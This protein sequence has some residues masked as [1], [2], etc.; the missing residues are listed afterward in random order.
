MKR[1]LFAGLLG[2]AAAPALAQ[3]G[4]TEIEHEGRGLMDRWVIAFNRGDADAMAADVY[5]APDTEALAKRFADLRAESFGKLDVYGAD[6][7]GRDST[8]GRAI[9][10]FARIYT[11]GGQMN[12]DE[13]KVFDFEKTGAGW[14]ITSE[15]DA[16]YATV[17]GC[18]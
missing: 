9:L 6:F 12:G 2:L 10:K 17:L 4:A 18:D 14:R 15:T 11:F 13:A 3:Q 5:A 8:H 1:V 16:T 7:C